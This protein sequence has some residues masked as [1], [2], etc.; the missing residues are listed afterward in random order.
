MLNVVEGTLSGVSRVTQKA[1]GTLT[2]VSQATQRA[3]DVRRTSR[4]AI[5]DRMY[6]AE[7][8]HWRLFSKVDFDSVIAYLRTNHI[9]QCNNFYTLQTLSKELIPNMTYEALRRRNPKLILGLYALTGKLCMRRKR[10]LLCYIDLASGRAKKICKFE[11]FLEYVDI[12]DSLQSDSLWIPTDVVFPKLR[13]TV[14]L[15]NAQ[16]IEAVPTVRRY[17]TELPTLSTPAHSQNGETSIFASEEINHV[18]VFL[19]EYQALNEEQSYDADKAFDC[20]MFALLQKADLAAPHEDINAYVQGVSKLMES[21][22]VTNF[23]DALQHTSQD[24]MGS[25]RRLYNLQEGDGASNDMFKMALFSMWQTQ[26]SKAI[27]DEPS[28]DYL[29]LRRRLYEIRKHQAE[30]AAAAAEEQEMQERLSEL[31][32]TMKTPT[33]AE[34]IIL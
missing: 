11:D 34:D 2:G 5:P 4:R 9:L 3:V 15:K 29:D 21:L 26:T 13:H 32:Q 31:S 30:E 7:L 17:M 10:G 24:V 28:Q 18:E 19:S 25:F 1:A 23:V 12:P 8:F 6:L 14:A 22:G 33:A 16:P 20:L 27:S